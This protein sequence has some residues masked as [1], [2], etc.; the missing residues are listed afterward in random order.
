M[1]KIIDP[2][3]YYDRLSRLP[4]MVVVSSDDE[5]MQFDWTNIW[6]NN[7]KGETHLLIA[8]N[9]EHSCATALPEILNTAAAMVMSIAY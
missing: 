1:A 9:S 6:Y 2:I 5:F 8:P 3:Y 4:K 7:I